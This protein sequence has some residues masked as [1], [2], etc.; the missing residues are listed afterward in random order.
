[1][2]GDC[3][4]WLR[5]RHERS[6]QAVVTDPP[7]GLVEYSAK[8][9]QKLR[10]GRGGVRACRRRSTES[11]RSPL[12]CFTTLTAADLGELEK[13]FFRWGC[14]LR[15][16]WCRCAHVFVASN[17]LI[18]YAVAGSRPAGLRRRGEIIRL[19]MTLRGGDRPKN[20]HDLFP[21]VSV[22]PRPMWEPWLLFREPIE[23]RVQDNLRKWKTGGAATDWQRSAVWRC[24]RVRTD[25]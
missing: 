19:V 10:N 7:Y 9:Q 23:G 14:L 15:R 3:M 6:I 16:G 24:Y 11:S 1:M 21:D 18:S 13:F 20:A 8:Q 4:E 12:P 17:P 22:M 25:A 2:L 5:L